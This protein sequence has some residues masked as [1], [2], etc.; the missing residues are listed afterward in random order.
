MGLEAALQR[1]SGATVQDL[2]SE[3]F[4]AD[5]VRLAGLYYDPRFLEGVHLYG[6]DV[7]WMRSDKSHGL[8]QIPTQ[9][10]PFLVELA[11]RKV[12]TFL[13]VGTFNGWTLTFIAAYLQRFGLER[14]LAL[15][16]WNLLDPACED[17]WAA[18]GLDIEYLAFDSEEVRDRAL[19]RYKK[20]EKPFDLAF[21]DADHSHEGVRADVK[22]YA[23]LAK[24]LAFHDVNDVFC[25]GVAGMW[26]EIAGGVEFTHH[27]RGLKVMGLGLVTL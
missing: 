14:A 22:V 16:R 5:A 1:L 27:S 2:L 21:I 12:K 4:V 18:H 10:A 9:L 24:A 17:L 26:A 13:D 8:W 20:A 7:E 11:G 3:E 23:P 15:D 6:D 25:P 19:A